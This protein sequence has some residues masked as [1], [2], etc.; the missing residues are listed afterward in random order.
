MHDG[1]LIDIGSPTRSIAPSSLIRN[2]TT[3]FPGMLAQMSHLPSGVIAKFCGPL[4]LL[5]VIANR[6][7]EPS[8]AIRYEAT[9]SCPR[10]VP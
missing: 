9:L 8:A 5:D 2:T 4:P 1:I 10:F 6:L 7:S 3:L